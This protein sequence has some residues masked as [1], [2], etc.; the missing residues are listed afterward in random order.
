MKNGATEIDASIQSMEQLGIDPVSIG[1]LLW[2]R[3]LKDYYERVIIIS[4]RSFTVQRTSNSSK[5][6]IVFYLRSFQSWRIYPA[7]TI[8]FIG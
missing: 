5:T 3:I 1:V 6:M 7:T 2:R 4:E 8:Y